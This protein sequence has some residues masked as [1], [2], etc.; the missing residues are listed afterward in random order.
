MSCWPTSSRHLFG[1]CAN[2]MLEQSSFWSVP[3]SLSLGSWLQL[4]RLLL[5]VFHNLFTTL[6]LARACQK[7]SSSTGSV[8]QTAVWVNPRSLFTKAVSAYF[9]S[10]GRVFMADCSDKQIYASHCSIHVQVSPLLS[11]RSQLR[12]LLSWL[13]PFP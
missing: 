10:T 12:V 2:R 7:P 6:Y 4:E 8:N 3:A 13:V 11:F 5:P 9:T 1:V